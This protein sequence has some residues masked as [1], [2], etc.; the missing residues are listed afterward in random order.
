MSSGVMHR[1]ESFH[2]VFLGNLDRRLSELHV[3]QL[4]RVFG[5]DLCSVDFK[6]DEMSGM[7]RG[8]AFIEMA[9]RE[10][11]ELVIKTLNGRVLAGRPLIANWANE[12]SHLDVSASGS[13]VPRFTV[14]EKIELI[15]EK[16]SQMDN[17]LESDS[18]SADL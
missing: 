16:L 9:T 15:K 12:R 13:E 10:S 3:I 4:V 14:E 8:F 1:K 2:S 18:G 11:A 7:P 5:D 17:D 6:Y